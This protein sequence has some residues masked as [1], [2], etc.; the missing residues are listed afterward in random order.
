MKNKTTV[1]IFDMDFTLVGE[2][3]AE[4]AER[5]AAHVDAKIRAVSD[6]SGLSTVASAILAAVNITDELFRNADSTE[7]L[8][9]Q[10]K[11]YFDELSR[12]K[13]ENYDLKRELSKLKPSENR[14]PEHRIPSSARPVKLDAPAAPEQNNFGEVER[15]VWDE[16]QETLDLGEK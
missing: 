14:I 2:E 5:V 9:S 7:H 15:E 16:N 12:L 3:S 6:G 11:D 13:D 1:T 4:Y 10:L 8:R